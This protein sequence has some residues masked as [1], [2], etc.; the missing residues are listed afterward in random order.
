MDCARIQTKTNTTSVKE[1]QAR[2]ISLLKTTF[3]NQIDTGSKLYDQMKRNLSC[4]VI[5]MSP[6]LEKIR[7][8]RPINQR[9]LFLQRNM[10]GEG[11]IMHWGCFSV[12]ER[13]V[14]RKPEVHSGKSWSGSSFRVSSRQQSKAHIAF[15]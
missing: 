10:V 9:T 4:L 14:E 1:L 12:Y 5:E 3:K 13:K 7:I 2:L 11:S 6:V 15:S 8:E